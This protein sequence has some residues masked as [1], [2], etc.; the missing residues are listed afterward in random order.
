MEQQLAS[1]FA[2]EASDEEIKVIEEW[3]NE[4]EENSRLFLEYKIAWAKS[5]KISPAK[6]AL[7]LIGDDSSQGEQT[8]IPIWSQNWFRFAASIILVV[9]LTLTFYFTQNFE[10]TGP[11]TTVQKLNDGTKVTLYKNA[12]F[13]VIS[14][15]QERRVKVDGK[16][17]FDVARDESKPFIILTEEARVEVLG[18]SFLVDAEEEYTT[19]VIVESGLVSFTHNPETYKN[20]TT[21]IKLSKGE[22][23]IITPRA[24]GIIKQNNRDENYL[25]WKTQILT[26]KNT[27]LSEVANKL[28]EVYGYEVE[29]E[30][31]ANIS[32]CRLTAKYD[33]KTPEEIARLVA[34]T[35][36]FKYTVV[37]GDKI[38]FEGQ[39]CQ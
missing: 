39:G 5:A 29:F 22:K 21:S 17:F 11:L 37:P 32:K 13:E 7:D 25:S 18:T 2:G 26:F 30:G 36:S 33:R 8:T 10:Q 20:V 27:S 34:E 35:F 15:E 3:R 31:N 19:E 9:G 38:I 4:S 28:Q 6:S 12:S 1:Y 14:M 16:V 23:G 24:K